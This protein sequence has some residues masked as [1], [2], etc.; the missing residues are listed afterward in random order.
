[1]AEA[2]ATTTTTSE[3]FINKKQFTLNILRGINKNVCM[4][5]HAIKFIYP[6][7]VC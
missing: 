6:I 5:E 4:Y 1:M 7:F 3:I 2:K